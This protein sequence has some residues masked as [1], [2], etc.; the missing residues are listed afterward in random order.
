MYTQVNNK[1]LELGT[2]KEV[3]EIDTTKEQV[4]AQETKQNNLIKYKTQNI[5]NRKDILKDYKVIS[6]QIVSK[7]K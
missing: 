2:L 5:I 7:N 1:L 4:T 6:S 3:E